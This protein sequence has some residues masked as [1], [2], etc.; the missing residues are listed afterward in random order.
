MVAAIASE[1]LLTVLQIIW[2]HAA[3]AGSCSCS[4]CCYSSEQNKPPQM[5]KAG[6]RKPLRWLTVV[7]CCSVLEW[8]AGVFQRSTHA[9]TC[10]VWT[11]VKAA[12]FAVMCSRVWPA[13]FDLQLLRQDFIYRW[14]LSVM[15]ASLAGWFSSGISKR[16]QSESK[17]IM[18]DRD[19]IHPDVF[20]LFLP[21]CPPKHKCFSWLRYSR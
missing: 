14:H 17:I 5:H 7:S 21:R 2:R 6:D 16:Q 4:C 12:V 10:S 19:Q 15:L 9:D 11:L 18:F 20:L 8:S 13:G 3:E 1:A